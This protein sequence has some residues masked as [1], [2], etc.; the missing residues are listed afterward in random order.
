MSSPAPSARCTDCQADV[1]LPPR[2]PL[3]WA[4]TA[5]LALATASAVAMLLCFRGGREYWGA[6][7]ALAALLLLRLGMSLAR[8]GRPRCPGC[9]SVL[10]R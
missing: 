8:R 3:E 4:G 6:G 7:A 9:G 5:T 1:A 2:R 10:W